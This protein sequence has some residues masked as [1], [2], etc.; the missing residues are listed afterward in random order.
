M[1][2]EGHVTGK[3]QR[4]WCPGQ[5]QTNFAL[6]VFEGDRCHESVSYIHCCMTPTISNLRHMM[7]L[8]NFDEA[9]IY[10]MQFSLVISHCNITFSVF[11]LSQ[12]S[13]AT[14]IRWGGWRSYHHTLCS[15]IS[16]QWKLYY[17]LLIFGEVTE[18]NKLAPFLYGPRC[19]VDYVV[20]TP[21]S[22]L[23]S[24]AMGQSVVHGAGALDFQQFNFI[25]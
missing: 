18:K 21:W 9:M 22:S 1:I 14:L 8:V 2:S 16:Q 10:L 6:S 15:F 5:S 4:Q 20:Y 24:L 25:S 17:N 13:V 12:G 7:T 11:W 23:T 3:S 19:T